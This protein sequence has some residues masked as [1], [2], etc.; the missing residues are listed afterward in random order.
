MRAMAVAAGGAVPAELAAKMSG[1]WLA[2]MAADVP[3]D[4]GRYWE[5]DETQGE[6]QPG[7]SYADIYWGMGP[8]DPPQ[9]LWLIGAR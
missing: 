6:A 4:G 7:A 2:V 1:P 9:G 3:V 8:F 5:P